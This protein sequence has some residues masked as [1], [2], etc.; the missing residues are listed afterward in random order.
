VAKGT[1]GRDDKEAKKENIIGLN[2]K[3]FPFLDRSE[4]WPPPDRF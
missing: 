4:R 1:F 2:R 3:K